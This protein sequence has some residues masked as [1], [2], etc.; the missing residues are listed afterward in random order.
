MASNDYRHHYCYPVIADLHLFLITKE[1]SLDAKRI[2][3]V[4]FPARAERKE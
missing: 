1:I 3:F 4:I 2:R